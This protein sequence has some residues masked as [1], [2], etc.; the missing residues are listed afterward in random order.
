MAFILIAFS[1]II[2]A[3]AKPIAIEFENY[4][5]NSALQ[6]KTGN[7]P[8]IYTEALREFYKERDYIPLWIEG[9]EIKRDEIQDI[10]NL[11]KSHAHQNGLAPDDYNFKLY[12][13]ENM[14]PNVHTLLHR[15]WQI[16]NTVMHYLHDI[17]SGRIKPHSFDPQIFLRPQQYDVVTALDKFMA[18]TNKDAFL[19]DF[20]PSHPEYNVLVK[21]LANYRE[22]AA[23]ENARP[24]VLQDK[25]YISPGEK[26]P[27]MPNIKKKLQNFFDQASFRAAEQRQNNLSSLIYDEATAEQV[28][29][30]QKSHGLQ[31]DGIIG[32]QTV[33]MLNMSNAQKVD[34]IKLALER[35]RWLPES[36]GE[37]HV[38]INIAAYY[39]RA[40]ENGRDAFV[41]PVIVG[42]VAHQTPVFSSVIE[43]VKMHPDWTVPDSIAE[44]YL[45]DKIQ[46][47]PS[48]IDTLGYQ[49][50]NKHTGDIIP[51]SNI[52][53]RNLHTIDLS[54]Y[55]FRQKPGKRNAL[56][57]ARFSIANDYS[58]FMHGTPAQNLFQEE[59]RTFSSG[60]IR[61][62]DAFK[63]AHF[64]LKDQG[65]TMKDIQREFGLKD[66]EFAQT[67]YIDLKRDIPVYLT[68]ATAWVDSSGKLHFAPDVY[69]RDQKLMATL[70]ED[71]A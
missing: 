16:T 39:V 46:N 61:V 52:D 9:S 26:H 59:R 20:R 62:Q 25:S 28:K 63:M 29:E 36:L 34:K 32:P 43:N 67:N 58:I 4:L 17:Q 7:T 31:I 11:L 12:K 68:Y 40:V 33:S 13:S 60:C 71:S 64:L 2:P 41:M 45:I 69:G 57:L 51:W 3:H 6:P 5:K 1:S 10:Q 50:Q 35:W 42:E 19:T 21:E 66:G 53:I 14:H 15:E 49:V 38:R 47:N 55:Q 70:K 22:K 44:R 23:S 48:V 56:G 8:T 24:I 18:S 27:A 65:Y 54:T 37:K 30:F